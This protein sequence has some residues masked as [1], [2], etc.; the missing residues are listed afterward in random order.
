SDLLAIPTINIGVDVNDMFG[1]TTGIYTHAGND[2]RAWERPASIEL[3]NP[4]GTPGF[5]V[6]A[7]I[8]IRGGFSR[9]SSNPKHAFRLFF[10]SQYGDS[11]LD[12]PLSGTCDEYLA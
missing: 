11:N 5:Q 8:R 7:G 6:N 9:S 2:T 10:R 1:A 12:Y 4:D 3:I